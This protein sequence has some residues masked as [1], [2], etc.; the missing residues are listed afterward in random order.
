[1]IVGEAGGETGRDGGEP[2]YR[3]ALLE[4]RVLAGVVR[5]RL[6]QIAEEQQLDRVVADIGEINQRVRR[7]F[8]LH[9]EVPTLHIAGARVARQMEDRRRQRVE[10]GRRR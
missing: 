2:G 3:A 5:A 10:V 8:A 7:D 9:G 4:R 6:I 1:M